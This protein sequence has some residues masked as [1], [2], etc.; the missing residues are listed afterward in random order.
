MLCL[1]FSKGRVNESVHVYFCTVSATVT[2]SAKIEAPDVLTTCSVSEHRRKMSHAFQQSGQRRAQ[3]QT[4]RLNTHFK[5]LPL[6]EL[7]FARDC[8]DR[9]IAM[10][11]Y[12]TVN[13]SQVLQSV[14]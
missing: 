2:R 8:S 6:R 10:V 5:C 13:M 11:W 7:L 1:F 12:G 4:M 9:C 14:S 3:L